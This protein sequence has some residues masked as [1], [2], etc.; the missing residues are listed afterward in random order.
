M[1]SGDRRPGSFAVAGEKAIV[2]QAV[3]DDG[4]PIGRE[5]E[6]SVDIPCGVLADSD[7]GVLTP[8]QPASDNAAIPHSFPI[9]FGHDVEWGQIVNRCH[10]GA[11][12]GSEHAP[13]AWHVQ[14]VELMDAGQ[15]GQTSLVPENILDGGPKAFGNWD[16]PREIGGE[17][18]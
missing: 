1:S 3:K 8:G 14:H 7:D 4:D 15:M 18:K 5:A 16:H 6:K 11:G 10:E 9:V 2:S 12:P 13:V 17:F